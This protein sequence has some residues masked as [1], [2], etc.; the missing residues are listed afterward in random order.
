MELVENKADKRPEGFWSEKKARWYLAGQRLSNFSETVMN[1]IRPRLAGCSSAL[2]I[3]AG[4]G[5]LSIPLARELRTVAA[6]EPS[7]AMMAL[8]K[9]E[10][11]R[12]GLHNVS[13]I[14]TSWGEAEIAPVDL[15]VSANVPGLYGEAFLRQVTAFARRRVVL[16]LSAG[17]EQDKFYYKELYPLLFGREFPPRPDYLDIYAC[18]HRMKIYADVNIVRYDFDQPFSNIDEAVEFWKEY[19]PLTDN[20][21]DALLADFLKNKLEP[22]E[23]GLIARFCKRSAVITWS[24]R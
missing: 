24:T 4:I 20:S 10:A 19:I 21:H 1:I 23:G 9:D 22:W 17:P 8:L 11:A 16:I 12:E 13:F 15:V 2:D 7:A 14:E 18:L 3:G 6:M 5:S